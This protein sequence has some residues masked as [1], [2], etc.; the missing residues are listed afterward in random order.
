VADKDE[1]HAR[2][3]QKIHAEQSRLEQDF[4]AQVSQYAELEQSLNFANH[5]IIDYYNSTSW[6]ITRPLRW[7]SKKL[8]G[9][10]AEVIK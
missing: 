8:R 5:E 7:I 6:K 1:T 10:S 2:E 9:G 3:L 4:N